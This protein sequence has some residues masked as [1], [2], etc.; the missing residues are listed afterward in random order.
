MSERHDA[1]TQFQL[2]NERTYLAWLR[3]S[4]GLV[5]VGVGAAR[6]LSDQRLHW[7]WE[8]VGVLLIL[9]GVITA[10]LARSRWKAI[11]AAVHDGRPIP[12]PGLA[13]LASAVIVVVGLL[14]IG[15]L[16]WTDGGN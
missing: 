11:D 14:A 12:A 15:L 7:A 3:T 4:L 2:A 8:A 5:A 13:V 16:L 6:L 9:A 10:G 1:E